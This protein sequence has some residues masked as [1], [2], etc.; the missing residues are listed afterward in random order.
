MF[1]HELEKIKAALNETSDINLDG[2][3]DALLVKTLKPSNLI[4]GNSKITSKQ[5]HIALSGKD[6]QDFFPYVDIYNY[7]NLEINDQNMKS[8]YVLQVPIILNKKNIEYATTDNLKITYNSKNQI[9]SKGSI[10]LSRPG[11]S[12]QI[13]LGNITTS[14]D[15]FKLFRSLFYESD[16]M[17]FLKVAQQ[18]EYEGYIIKKEDVEKFGLKDIVLFE[19]NRSKA[20]LVDLEEITIDTKGT[21]NESSKSY[22]YFEGYNVIYYGAPGTGKSFKVNEKIKEIYPNFEKE[23]AEFVFRTTL[24][25]EFSYHDFIGQ[26][27]PVI[28]EEKIEYDFVEGIF[29]KALD[30]AL[31]LEVSNKPVYLVLEELSRANV[32]AVFGDL[33]QLLDRNEGK[34]EYTITNALIAKY[35]YKDNKYTKI[36]IPKNLMIL[37]TVNTNDQNVFIMDTAFKRRFEWEYV[38]TKP[39]SDD[40]THLILNN[41]KIK[42]GDNIQINWSDFYSKLNSYITKEMKLGEDKQIGQFFIKF[43]EVPERN[44]EKIKNKLLQYLWDDVENSSYSGKKIFDNIDSFSDLYEKFGD[45]K[46]VFNKEFIDSLVDETPIFSREKELNKD[47]EE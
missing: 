6:S 27:M 23:E 38:S 26:I 12:P 40:K 2:K 11:N 19:T 46:S 29:T 33:F 34:S 14:D 42:I 35:I 8:F 18:V 7:T 41:P 36:Y 44:Q 28:N 17:I 25:P 9:V 1:K 20:T 3:Y 39:V 16:V 32:A 45:G 24:H 21:V 43:S 37:G 5:S 47:V 13:E 10:K 4:K 30:K 15:I 31:E 22:N